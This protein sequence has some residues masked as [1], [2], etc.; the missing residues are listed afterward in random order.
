[1]EPS[2]VPFDAQVGGHLWSEGKI[3]LMTSPGRVFKP[4]QDDRGK[5]ELH[6]YQTMHTRPGGPPWFLPRFHGVQ[7]IK[8]VAHLVLEDVTG[9]M[10]RPCV[11]DLKV[12]RRCY[13]PYAGPEKIA[14]ELSKYA[15]QEVI[16]F[17]CA[18]LRLQLVDNVVI[19]KDKVW[20]RTVTRETTHVLWATFF[21]KH[22]ARVLAVLEQLK[23][24]HQWM[25]ENLQWELYA[26]SVLLCY[27]DASSSV[28]VRV[29]DFSYAYEHVQGY[30]DN[31][32]FGLAHLIND[33]QEYYCK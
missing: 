25:L 12:G 9:D 5:R 30:N 23:G 10:E 29:V 33:L 14:S 31:F 19:R 18:G 26:C 17:R 32:T 4:L 3:G 16:G 24:I 6:F 8:G 1:M 20:G 13:T 28:R 11:M 7:N 2:P 15:L 21:G 22:T 27:D